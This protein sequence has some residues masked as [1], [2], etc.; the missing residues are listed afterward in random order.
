MFIPLVRGVFHVR[1]SL[2]VSIVQSP[3]VGGINASKLT[4]FTAGS[5]LQH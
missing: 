5:D 3:I 1:E 2:F 4:L